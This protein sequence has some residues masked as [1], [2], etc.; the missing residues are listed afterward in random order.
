M[1]RPQGSAALNQ[2]RPAQARLTAGTCTDLIFEESLSCDPDVLRPVQIKR[3]SFGR[4]GGKGR[5]GY[6][7]VAA[8][9]KRGCGAL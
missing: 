6:R 8:R 9:R 4:I 1:G 5:V 7:L 2:N 3:K